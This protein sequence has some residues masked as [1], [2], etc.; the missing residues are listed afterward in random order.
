METLF[1]KKIDMPFFAFLLQYVTAK[2]GWLVNWI[3]DKQFV[4]LSY[5]LNMG[6]KLNLE[7]P[8][9]YNEKLQWI[10]LYDRNPL[11]SQLADKYAVRTFVESRIGCEFLIP[12]L[13]VWNDVYDIRIE[14]LPNQFVLKCNHDSGGV[15][16]CKDKAKL[17]FEKTRK[18]LIKRLKTNF[19]FRSREWPYKNIPRKIIAEEYMVDESGY[20]LKDYKFFCFNGTCRLAFIATDRGIDTRFDFYDTDFNHL[21]IE[22]GHKNSNKKIEKPKNWESMINIA[23]KLSAGIPQVRVD[24]YDVLGK[25]YFGEMTLFHYGGKKPFLPEKWDYILGSYIDLTGITV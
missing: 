3:P 14:D 15:V 8:Q 11:Y 24:L 13:G 16:I 21:P 5:R 2:V 17:D 25:I 9:T 7:N 4:E 1:G 20:E 23:E 12:L 19:Y 18:F 6:K 10:K 22:N